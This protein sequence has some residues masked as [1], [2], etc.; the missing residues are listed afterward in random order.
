MLFVL[1]LVFCALFSPVAG[2]FGDGGGPPSTGFHPDSVAGGLFAVLCLF[3]LAYCVLSIWALI[4]SRGH[5]APYAV[6]FPALLF[7]GWSN[8]MYMGVILVENTPSMN[9]DFPNSSA[10]QLLPI[11]VSVSNLFSDWA[12]VLLFLG[13]VLLILNRETALKTATEGTSGGHK[14]VLLAAH[15]TLAVLTW[16]FGTAVEAYILETSLQPGLFGPPLQHQIMVTW[17]LT[18]A[19]GSCAVLMGVDVMVS[20]VFLW[21]AWRGA[22]ISD[23]I[24]NLMLY[25][26]IPLWTLLSLVN[27]VF[28][29]VFSPRGIAG[30]E[31]LY[32]GAAL[33]NF[34]LAGGLGIGI[35]TTLLL[36]SAKRELWTIVARPAMYIG[37]VQP[38]VHASLPSAPAP[39]GAVQPGPGAP[40]QQL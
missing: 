37:A 29:V 2:Q 20:T 21:R 33:A 15:I 4:M 14:P 30:D 38:Y 32:E 31:T 22:G 39:K 25:A 11:L 26:V 40:P 34:L 17:A 28:S 13:T 19:Y 8:A 7:A 3:T 27:M 23:K 10:E 6:L 18:Y 9:S 1:A 5:R 24:T 36:M 35:A 16:I 12:L